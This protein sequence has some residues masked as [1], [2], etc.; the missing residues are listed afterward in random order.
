MKAAVLVACAGSATRRMHVAWLE[1]ADVPEAGPCV[2]KPNPSPSTI[3]MYLPCS[4]DPQ[5]HST[6]NFPENL[7]Q[8]HFWDGNSRFGIRAE[9]AALQGHAAPRKHTLARRHSNAQHILK[10]VLQ[11]SLH[12]SSSAA[13]LKP[14]DTFCSGILTATS[15][16]TVAMLS[17]GATTSVANL[18]PSISLNGSRRSIAR[19]RAVFDYDR[20][21]QARLEATDAFKELQSMSRKQSVNKPQK[22][23]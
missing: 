23:R 13:L 2:L 6:E 5:A 16:A 10:G 15:K 19:V 17:C 9:L 18:R 12:S 14:S 4:R 21:E 8:G 22:V 1:G 7:L 3:Y 11:Y 20:A